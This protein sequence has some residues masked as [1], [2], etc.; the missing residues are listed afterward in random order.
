MIQVYTY[1]KW[2]YG[3]NLGKLKGAQAKLIRL[4][5]LFFICVKLINHGIHFIVNFKINKNIMAIIKVPNYLLHNYTE[6]KLVDT[7]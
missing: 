5:C 1:V 3:G 2:V 4:N 6:I 7:R